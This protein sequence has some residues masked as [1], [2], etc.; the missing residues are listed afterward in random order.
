MTLIVVFQAL[1]ESHVRKLWK[2]SRCWQ[3]QEKMYF[4][5]AGPRKAVS[6]ASDSRARGFGFDTRSGH[7]LKFLLPLIQEGRA[8]VSYLRKY[9]HEVLVNSLGSQ[10]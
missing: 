3:Q 7:I 6:S 1:L 10:S 4:V 8:V 5:M 9:M 2:A